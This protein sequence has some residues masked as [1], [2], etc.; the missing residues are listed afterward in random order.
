MTQPWTIALISTAYDLLDERKAIIGYLKDYQV[1]VSAFEEADYPI[2]QNIH[3]HENCVQVL[4]RADIVIVLVNQRYGGKFY[5]NQQHSITEEEYHNI[6]VPTVVL[7][8]DMVWEERKIYRT[9]LKESG[10]AEAEFDASGRY[11]PSNV[12]SV[13]VFHFLDHIQKVYESAGRSNWMNYWHDLKELM[14]KLPLTLQALS[15]NLVQSI[16]DKQIQEVTARKTSTALF[17]SLGDVIDKEYYLEPAFTVESGTLGENGIISARINE[18]VST[19]ESCIVLADAGAG[20]T[21]LMAK[22]FLERA[23]NRRNVFEIPA[24]VWLKDKALEYSFSLD[25]YIEDCFQRYLNKPHYPFFKEA[26][27][28]YT[29]FLDGFDEFAEKLSKEDLNRLYSSEVFKFPMILTSRTQYAEKYLT[30]N[31][32]SSKFSCRIRLEEWS[33]EMAQE[34]IDKFCK[35]QNKGEEFKSRIIGLLVN[36]PDLNEVL[37]S[38]LLVTVLLYVIEKNRM[39]LPE[40]V[41]SRAGLLQKCLESL[42]EREI[43][44][45]AAHI[46]PIPEKTDLVLHWSYFAWYHYEGKLLRKSPSSV[47]EVRGKVV[48]SLKDNK[49]S[50]F[51]ESVYSVIFNIFDNSVFGTFHEQFLE[52]LVANALVYACQNKKTPYPNFLRYVLRPEIN[53]YFRGIVETKTPDEQQII[54]K[55][56]YDLFMDSIGSTEKDRIAQRVHAV[57]HLS[58]LPNPDSMA[59]MNRLFNIEQERSVRQSLYFGIIKRGDMAREQEFYDLLIKDADYSDANR[60]YHLAYYDALPGQHEIPYS[61]DITCDWNGTLRAFKRHFEDADIEHYYLQRIDLV[62]M[63]QL[64]EFRKSVRPLTEKDISEFESYVY[65]PKVKVD[66][67]FQ[68]KIEKEFDAVKETFVRFK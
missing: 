12:D 41:T 15:I 27:L 63:R 35:L 66:D 26:S 64:M 31:D 7:V 13:E 23:Q 62:T 51:P 8:N 58:R 55:S 45:K 36:N 52:F 39:T 2:I 6:T 1:Q 29:F 60:G 28:K 42:A 25:A 43:E 24:Y 33:L 59:L 37:K 57:Y 56:I 54:F 53:R 21:T 18:K 34:Y 38:P 10:M 50:N 40:T 47:A 19:G 44:T 4:N 20:K 11:K 49:A 30:S 48:E 9:Q 14:E 5:L 32:F 3:S 68:R 65:H 22:C 16:I 17:M 67:G 61:D 46:H